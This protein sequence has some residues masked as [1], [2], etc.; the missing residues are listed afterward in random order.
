MAYI[1]P[2]TYAE[3]TCASAD[4][5]VQL[6]ESLNFEQ[7]AC[8]MLQGLTG[9]MLTHE[10]YRVQPGD[11][12]LVHAAAGGT[13]QLLCQICK[14]MGARV[15]GTTSTP[16]K[17]AVAKQAGADDVILY[18]QEDVVAKVKALTNGTGVNVVYDGVGKA[19]F[20]LSLASL[21]PRGWMISFGN[22]SG[23]PEP[24]DILRL[25][26][27]SFTLMRP[28]LFDFVATKADF[29]RCMFIYWIEKISRCCY[30]DE[31]LV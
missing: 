9:M 17:A 11:V 4:K 21:R 20:D 14:A 19:T 16:E 12:V 10:T 25:A 15:I 23:K 30:S 18:T 26:K 8:A 6:P 28:T 1:G 7:G 24:F 29:Q 5:S 13:G 22:A 27:G 31:H 3:Y 2:K